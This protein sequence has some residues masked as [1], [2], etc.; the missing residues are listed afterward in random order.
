MLVVDST[1]AAL[2]KGQTPEMRTQSYLMEQRL[3]WLDSPIPALDGLTPREAVEAGRRAEVQA[4]IPHE[5]SWLLAALGMDA[6][7]TTPE[8]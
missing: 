4:L 3:D 6:P 5:E 8:A 7:S 1:V 2:E